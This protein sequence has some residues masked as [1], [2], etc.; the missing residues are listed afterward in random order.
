MLNLTSTKILLEFAALATTFTKQT[1]HEVKEKVVQQKNLRP[2]LVFHEK[3]LYPKVVDR[4]A[5]T[6][7]SKHNAVS[8]VGCLV[9]GTL[10]TNDK[11]KSN[12][13]IKQ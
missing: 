7:S 13:M 2:C 8:K 9:E 3:I 12:Q 4:G 1:K 10:Q 11:V 5:I 6:L